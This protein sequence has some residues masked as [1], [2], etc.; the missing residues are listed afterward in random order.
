MKNTLSLFISVITLLFAIC[1]IATSNDVPKVCIAGAGSSG[2]NMAWQLKDAGYDFVVYEPT[3]RIGGHCN[4]V[5]FEGPEGPSWEDC[6]VVILANTTYANE[7]GFGPWSIDMVATVERFAGPGSAVPT[8]F[9]GTVEYAADFT[10]S[11]DYG[12]FVGDFGPVFIEQL[13]ALFEFIPSNYPWMDNMVSPP[14]PLPIELTIPF[15]DW[16]Q[17]NGFSALNV[18]F[19]ASLWLGGNGNFSKMSALDALSNVGTPTDLLYELSNPPGWFSVQNGCQSIYD[20]I[21]NYITP[22]KVKLNTTLIYAI[23]PPNGFPGQVTLYGYQNGQPF[24]DVCD[25]F[26][27][28]FPPT[29]Q[30]ILFMG[31]DFT[32]IEVFESVYFVQEMSSVVQV[33]GP[34][35]TSGHGFAVANS[36]RSRPPL[37]QPPSPLLLQVSRSRTF[38]P[39]CGYG[40]S[41]TPIDQGLLQSVMRDQASNIPSTLLT[42]SVFTQFWNHD[43]APHWSMPVQAGPVSPYLMAENL[44]GY[45]NTYWVGALYTTFDSTKIWNKNHVLMAQHFPPV[46]SKKHKDKN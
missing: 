43:F 13:L 7:L 34:V 25:K 32:E 10:R 40:F 29:L 44:Q 8:P 28:A 27:V 9:A 17:V 18:L 22:E 31:P 2:M 5:R 45:R 1:N 14:S 33:Q 41:Q 12:V 24:I 36:D 35:T 38:G 4:T 39:A 19:N 42:N 3:G 11:I 15:S 21:L 20:G 26:I 16:L 30:N 37:N 46:Q 6:G 23:R